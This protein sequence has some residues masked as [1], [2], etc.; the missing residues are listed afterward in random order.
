MYGQGCAADVCFFLFLNRARNSECAFHSGQRWR[1]SKS[2]PHPK[3][4]PKTSE[5][6]RLVV[7]DSVPEMS[8]AL[9]VYVYSKCKV[10]MA[11]AAPGGQE[12][13]VV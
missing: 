3:K 13:A 4:S 1:V 2:R 11:L 8:H 6:S 12:C 5:V 7:R 10:T 9:C